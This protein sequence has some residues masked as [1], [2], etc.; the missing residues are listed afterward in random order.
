MSKEH[1]LLRADVTGINDT[2]IC[3][4]EY[5]LDIHPINPINVYPIALYDEIEDTIITNF[6]LFPQLKEQKYSE[7]KFD[8]V[9]EIIS[10]MESLYYN[11]NKITMTEINISVVTS[12]WN[13]INGTNFTY[14][15]FEC[16]FILP[17]V[18]EKLDIFF[19]KENSLL[20]AKQT[21]FSKFALNE[22]K[23]KR[24]NILNNL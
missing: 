21:L 18:K 2:L 20:N 7:D 13:S 11:N 1:L 23:E 10:N 24:E 4:V 15:D 9:A 17:F 3:I 5:D 19:I 12:Y 16:E 22:I 8:Q 14:E 6:D